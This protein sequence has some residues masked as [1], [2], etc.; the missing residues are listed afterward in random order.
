MTFL[1]VGNP[2]AEW[3][4][5]GDGFI[6]IVTSSLFVE[7]RT[8]PERWEAVSAHTCVIQELIDSLLATEFPLR[9]LNLLRSEC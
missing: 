2:E 9:Y 7:H 6:R 8:K 1:A 5:E 3:K 4:N